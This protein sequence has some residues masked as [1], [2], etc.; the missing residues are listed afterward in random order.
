M[1]H[2]EKMWRHGA[3]VALIVA[4]STLLYAHVT[5]SYFCGYDDFLDVQRAQ[6]VDQFDPGKIL[7]TTHYGSFKYRPIQRVSNLLSYLAAPG[8]AIGFR[9]RNLFFHEL[10]AIA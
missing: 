9:A 8:E 1:R 6:F 4:F 5:E 7:T 10:C 3:G 2:F